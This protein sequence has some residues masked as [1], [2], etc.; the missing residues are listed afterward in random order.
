MLE[1]ISN[2]FT[3]DIYKSYII[4]THQNVDIRIDSLYIESIYSF[5]SMFNKLFN[6]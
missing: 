6:K 2:I 4:V 1:L 5:F 3:L